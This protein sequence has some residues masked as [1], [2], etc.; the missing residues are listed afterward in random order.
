MIGLRACRAWS[1]SH[2]HLIGPRAAEAG[3]SAP[4]GTHWRVSFARSR[5]YWHG[6]QSSPPPPPSPS[7]PPQSAGRSSASALFGTPLGFRQV[8]A[9]HLLAAAGGTVSA[10]L[11]ASDDISDEALLARWADGITAKHLQPGAALSAEPAATAAPSRDAAAAAAPACASS[12]ARLLRIAQTDLPWPPPTPT[13]SARGVVPELASKAHRVS[14]RSAAAANQ[15]DTQSP[16]PP[17]PP[18]HGTPAHIPTPAR[19]A[20]SPAEYAAAA[21][22]TWRE[23]AVRVEAAEANLRGLL[24]VCGHE[25]ASAST[26]AHTGPQARPQPHPPE[27]DAS[28]DPKR[29]AAAR[30]ALAWFEAGAS[31]GDASAAFNAAVLLDTMPERDAGPCAHARAMV[32]YRQAAHLSHAQAQYNLAVALLRDAAMHAGAMRPDARIAEARMWVAQAARGGVDEAAALKALLDA[33]EAPSEPR[34]EPVVSAVDDAG[35]PLVAASPVGAVCAALDDPNATDA[36]L[37][38]VCAAAADAGSFVAAFN[39]GVLLERRQQWEAAC[40]RYKRAAESPD[41]GLRADALFN[42]ACIQLNHLGDRDAAREMLS[43]AEALGDTEAAA[44]LE[45]L[46]R[47]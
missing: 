20:A 47:E 7:P 45:S 10:H 17:S 41:A 24:L 42:L 16:P 14:V 21:A 35:D 34:S 11:M 15:T 33:L 30:Q 23:S 40:E 25:P 44:A 18:Q 8:L 26:P 27:P 13:P 19:L 39:A 12:E 22:D 2:S 43:R 5:A 38:A 37:L 9:G 3:V 6:P 28:S 31:L 4:T 46:A 29:R 36:Q 1:A 32:L